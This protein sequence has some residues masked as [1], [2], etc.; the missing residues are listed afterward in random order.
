[1]DKSIEELICD[2]IDQALRSNPKHMGLE[3]KLD[4]SDEDVYEAMMEYAS[5]LGEIAYKAGLK[6]GVRLLLKLEVA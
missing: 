3:H 1:M 4:L 6:D 2:R 5:S